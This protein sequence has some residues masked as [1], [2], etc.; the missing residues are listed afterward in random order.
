MHSD[1]VRRYPSVN[2]LPVEFHQLA[3]LDIRNFSLAHELVD[4]MNRQAQ[5]DRDLLD[6]EQPGGYG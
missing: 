6:I 3:K 5:I 1:A 2:F 4:G